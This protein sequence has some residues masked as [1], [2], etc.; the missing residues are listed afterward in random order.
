[1]VTWPHYQYTR[2]DLGKKVFYEYLMTGD[3]MFAIVKQKHKEIAVKEAK[4]KK[5]EECVK[6]AL[7]KLKQQNRQANKKTIPK[8]IKNKPLL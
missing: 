2:E 8:K 7:A 6:T 5:K 3:K 1:M 4:T